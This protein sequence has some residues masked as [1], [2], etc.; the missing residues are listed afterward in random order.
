MVNPRRLIGLDPGL[1]FLGWGIVEVSANKLTHIANGTVR[2]TPKTDLAD[3]LVEL[4]SGLESVMAEFSPQLAAVEN[5]FVNRDAAASLK[6]GQ[7]RAICLLVPAR[8]G[9]KVAEY[10]PNMIK[11]SVTGSGHADKVQMQTMVSMLLPNCKPD[12]EHAADALAVAIAHAHS[13]SLD[14]R[15]AVK[16]ADRK[17][18][19]T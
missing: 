7:A 8:H 3:R 13:G 16:G 2:S 12:S 17:R 6:L 9:L 11:K 14:D 19:L 5:T 15:L 18:Q 4:E 1:R 10:A